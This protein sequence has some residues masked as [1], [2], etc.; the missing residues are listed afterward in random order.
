MRPA[1]LPVREIVGRRIGSDP[2][3]SD[4]MR[5][6]LLE[7]IASVRPGSNHAGCEYV[8]APQAAPENRWRNQWNAN[9][10]RANGRH[11]SAAQVRFVSDRYTHQVASGGDECD[12]DCDV[13]VVGD[14]DGR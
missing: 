10:S 1:S 11:L 8:R 6:D 3:G 5:S 9:P 2:F 13:D 12:C 14:V 7:R 4:A